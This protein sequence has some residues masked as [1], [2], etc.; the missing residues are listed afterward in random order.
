[1]DDETGTAMCDQCAD[2]ALSSGVFTTH[3]DDENDEPSEPEEGDYVT[4]DHVHWYEHGTGKLLLTVPEDGDYKAA[5]RDHME[6][7]ALFSNVWFLS[8]HG[9]AHLIDIVG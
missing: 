1:M 4:T 2:D 5:I 6:D 7:E 3:D 9:N 8:D